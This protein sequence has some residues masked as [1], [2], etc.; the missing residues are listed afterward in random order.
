MKQGRDLVSGHVTQYVTPSFHALSFHA[1]L[2]PESV[3][4]SVFLMS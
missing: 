2:S 4:A 1:D 3:V